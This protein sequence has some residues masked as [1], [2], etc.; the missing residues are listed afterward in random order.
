MIE[1]RKASKI[2]P[3]LALAVMT[4][5]AL[6]TA[7][8]QLDLPEQGPRIATVEFTSSQPGINPGYYSVVIDSMG[9]ASYWSLPNSDL[10]T[11]SPYSV[12]F[13]VSAQ[14]RAEIFQLTQQLRLVDGDFQNEYSEPWLKSL[15]FSDG[16]IEHAIFYTNSANPSM[17][18]LTV[19]FE[20]IA[21]TL[22]FGRRLAA[23]RTRNP[24][25]LTSELLQ[26]KQELAQGNLAEV[27]AIAPT[28]Q[29]V[30]SDS[31]VPEIARRYAGDILQQANQ[32]SALPD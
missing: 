2:I 3:V 17:N 5:V 20:K 10:Q 14:T 31:A 9:T 11:G 22:E 21:D 15:T 13:E 12:E 19:L 23:F 8:A 32:P 16:P 26:M 24:Q 25:G 28:L 18:Q 1:M 7:W 29:A 4:A 30:A 6:P 27:R